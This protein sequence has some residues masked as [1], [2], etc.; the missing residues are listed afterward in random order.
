MKK[1]LIALMIISVFLNANKINDASKSVVRIAIETDKNLYTGTAFSVSDGYYITNYHVISETLKGKLSAIAVKSLLPKK[2]LYPVKVVWYSQEKDLALL[3]IENLNFPPLKFYKNSLIEGALNVNSIGFPAIADRGNYNNKNFT[4]PKISTGTVA[5]IPFK[6]RLSDQSMAETYIIQHDATINGGNSGGP[7]VD[8][9]GRV[10]G[11]NV[12]TATG[13]SQGIH[14]AIAIDEVKEI[15]DDQGIIYEE[16]IKTCSVEN[17]MKN[18]LSIV[19]LILLGIFI[20]I[21]IKINK[22]SKNTAPTSS[23]MMQKVSEYMKLKKETITSTAKLYAQD[24]ELPSI[25]LS[26]DET[27]NIGQNKSNDISIENKF[28][29]S[30]H[31]SIS[32]KNTQVFVEDLGS[33]NGTYIDGKKLEAHKKYPLNKMEKLILG[34][35]EIIYQIEA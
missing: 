1:I 20:W 24:K 19:G 8:D 15:L 14:Y 26:E 16:D 29:S 4:A 35:E 3:K 18:I 34:S 21:F 13:G 30:K 25:V 27:L 6:G 10:V 7:L 2:E 28:I 17:T 9:C 12:Q 32:L 11:V 22:N 33:T 23:F 31:L 5:S